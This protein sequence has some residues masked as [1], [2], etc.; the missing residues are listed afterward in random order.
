MRA[1]AALSVPRDTHRLVRGPGGDV[2]AIGGRTTRYRTVDEVERF[3]LATEEWTVVGRL[4]H[5]RL[6]AFA[7]TYGERILVIGGAHQE[8]GGVAET[9]WLTF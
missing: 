6:D 8:E 5:P 1:T 4:S 9:E 7:A 2:F 3:S